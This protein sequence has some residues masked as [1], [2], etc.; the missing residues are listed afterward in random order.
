MAR[1]IK[2]S[3]GLLTLVPDPVPP[4]CCHATIRKPNANMVRL[5]IEKASFFLN[6]YL[7]SASGYACKALT[8]LTDIPG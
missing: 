4:K 5:E 3:G 7:P 6:R 1:G 2:I 8:V